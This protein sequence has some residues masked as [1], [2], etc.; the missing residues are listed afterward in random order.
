M[1]Q[2]L[3]KIWARKIYA[4]TK[5]LEDVEEKYGQDGVDAVK[6]AYLALYGVEL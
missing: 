5:T 6:A 2:S 1:S 3:A 4:G